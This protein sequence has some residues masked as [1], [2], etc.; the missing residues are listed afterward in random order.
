MT[1]AASANRSLDAEIARPLQL[2]QRQL[3]ADASHELRTPITTLRTNLEVLARNPDMPREELTPLLRDLAAE[4][5][6]LGYLVDDLLVTARSEQ[7]L[8]TPEL[9]P[10]DEIVISEVERCRAKHPDSQISVDSQPVTVLGS[11]TG[12][13]RAVANLLDNAVKWS[14]R[15]AEIEVVLAGGALTV[16]DH[17][18]GFR[19][20]DL[21]RVFDRFY[22]VGV[23][24]NGSGVGSRTLDRR[25]G[26]ARALRGRE[27][28]QRA[29]R[30]GEADDD[31]SG[32]IQWRRRTS[33]T[34]AA[35]N[36]GLLPIPNSFLTAH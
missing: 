11:E 22:L 33:R 12:L 19:P 3:L 27:R 21:P 4:S 32:R 2:A 26:R 15:G 7:E 1:W 10:L 14:P 13:R 36:R 8:A 25:E 35:V 29:R 9:V 16:R 24:S 31:A 30:R 28:G 23:G 20:D 6:D 5:A 18:P 17:G 34:Y